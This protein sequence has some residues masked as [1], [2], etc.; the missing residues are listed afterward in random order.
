MCEV[1]WFGSADCPV[2]W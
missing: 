1:E 2:V